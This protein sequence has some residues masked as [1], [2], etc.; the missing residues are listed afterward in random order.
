M[1]RPTVDPKWAESADPSDVSEPSAERSSGYAFEEPFTNAQANWLF[2]EVF[3]WVDY[4]D[5]KFQDAKGLIPLRTGIDYEGPAPGD[6]GGYFEVTEDDTN[7]FHEVTHDRGTANASQFVSDYIKGGLKVL[8]DRFQAITGDRLNILNAAGTNYQ[9]EVA[10]RNT[11]VAYGNFTITYDGSNWSLS[12]SNSFNIDVAA[13]GVD[14][15][16]ASNKIEIQFEDTT[17]SSTSTC[18]TTGIFNAQGSRRYMAQIYIAGAAG[19]EIEVWRYDETN[20]N[21]VNTILS[22]ATSGE[23][24]AVNVICF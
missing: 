19:I 16:G 14:T 12:V 9:G 7:G 10:A 24:I 3:R 6:G 8:G 4:F 13:S 1:A 15:V 23:Q 22:P 17:V 2:R 5:D 11:A 18:I 21:W 20:D